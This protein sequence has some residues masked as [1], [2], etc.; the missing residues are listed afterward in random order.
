M[1]RTSTSSLDLAYISEF[2]YLNGFY[3]LLGY[4]FV[5]NEFGTDGLQLTMTRRPS[6]Y[7]AYVAI[8]W[9]VIIGVFAF[10]ASEAINMYDEDQ[11]LDRATTIVYS[12]RTISVQVCCFILAFTQAPSLIQVSRDLTN[13]EAELTRPVQF[14]GTARNLI[15]I[16]ITLTVAQVLS[17]IPLLFFD[18]NL[19]VTQLIWN[20]VYLLVNAIHGQSRAWWSTPGPCSSLRRSPLSWPPLIL[21][22]STSW[23]PVASSKTLGAFY[24]CTDSLYELRKRSKCVTRFSGSSCSSY[25]HSTWYWRHRGVTG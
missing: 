11:V 15:V 13:L 6:L 12:V 14:S 7:N 5:G 25:F 4:T 16:N 3:R 19:S 23:T 8:T 2:R 10:D 22:S 9:L 1:G 17:I 21:S 18:E 20:S 24:E